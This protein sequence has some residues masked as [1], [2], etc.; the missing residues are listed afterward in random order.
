M[1]KKQITIKQYQEAKQIMK[2][3]HEQDQEKLEELENIILPLL[4]DYGKKGYNYENAEFVFNS[5]LK[6]IFELFNSKGV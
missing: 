6:I 3:Y 4:I 2:K 1:Y 5:I